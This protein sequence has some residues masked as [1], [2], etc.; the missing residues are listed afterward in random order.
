L[1]HSRRPAGVAYFYWF[2][3]D[4]G[5]L[6]IIRHVVF[7]GITS[8]V[9][10]ILYCVYMIAYMLYD[11]TRCY[12]IQITMRTLNVY[13]FST[14][15]SPRVSINPPPTD[16]PHTVSVSDTL[17]LYCIAKGQPI[18]TIKW[19]KNNTLI[20]QQLGPLYPV[21]TDSPHITKYTCEGTNNAGNMKN[22]ASASIIV[23]VEGTITSHH[24]YK[25]TLLSLCTCSC[26]YS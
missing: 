9:N 20:L 4:S 8:Q 6:C 17:F 26:M 15:D 11:C 2:C 10:F 3:L 7:C 22:T 23:E 24:K 13:N 16:S 12:M 18:P 19:Y 5:T 21:P 14:L 1:A 25:Y